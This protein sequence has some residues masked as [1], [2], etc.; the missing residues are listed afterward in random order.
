LETRQCRL[1]VGIV[2]SDREPFTTEDTEDTEKPGP[3]TDDADFWESDIMP[4]YSPLALSDI[5]FWPVL[6]PSCVVGQII[7]LVVYN[8]ARY[9]T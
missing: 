5:Y 2:Y 3:T 4:V 8:H 6:Q 7:E 1:Y 9:R